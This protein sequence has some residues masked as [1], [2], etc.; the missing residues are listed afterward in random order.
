[1]SL[2]AKIRKYHEEG[3]TVSEIV[4]KLQDEGLK[5]R[6]QRVYNVLLPLG[7]RTSGRAPGREGIGKQIGEMLKEGKS[8]K[9]I[10]IELQVY[11][12]QVYMAKKRLGQE[13]AEVEE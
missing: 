13:P 10:C 4:K 6:Y 9:E 3:L 2:N 11:P 12:N 1:M 7:P 8:V 5:V